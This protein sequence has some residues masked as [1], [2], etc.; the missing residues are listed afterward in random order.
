MI[1]FTRVDVTPSTAWFALPFSRRKSSVAG[2][3]LL[4]AADAA[5]AR[6]VTIPRA[7]LVKR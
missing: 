7:I 3:Q 2:L 5:I 6:Q 4:A 1:L